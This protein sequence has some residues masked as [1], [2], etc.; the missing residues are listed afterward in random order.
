MIAG[1]D[2]AGRG[3]L[4]GPVVAAACVLPV[5]LFVRAEH[6]WSPFPRPRKHDCVVA[7]S[8]SL[9]SDEREDAYAWIVRH[10]PFGIGMVDGADIDR[11]GILSATERAMQD[12]LAELARRMQPTY[13][14]VDG[15]DKFWF[16]Y[17]HSSIIDGDLKEPVIAAA[18]I[19]AKVTRDRLMVE[20]DR[21]FPSYGFARHKGYGTEE[22]MEAIR[23]FGLTPLHR[24]TFAKGISC[25]STLRDAS[26]GVTLRRS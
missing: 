18:S 23:R 10:C 26:P 20:A 24:K 19:I 4:A 22:H 2:E 1:I 15:R 11:I 12:A 21:A 14:L 25:V 7:D 6:R 3:P 9:T 17:P 5:P 16:D 13:L 8:K